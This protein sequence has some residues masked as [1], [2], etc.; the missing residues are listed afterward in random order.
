[1]ISVSA[2][3]KIFC[4]SRCFKITEEM[5]ALNCGLMVI[6]DHL[7]DNLYGMVFQ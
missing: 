3:R 7:M 6:M 2:C 5:Q 4:I 1:M